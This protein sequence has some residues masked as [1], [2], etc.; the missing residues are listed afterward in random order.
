MRIAMAA[1]L[2]ALVL[3]AAAPAAASTEAA[4][5]ASARNGREACIATARLLW[6]TVSAA[7]GFSDRTGYDAM[8]VRG[9]YPQKFMKGA[10]GTMLCLYDRR[11]HRTEAVEAK[12]WA[13]H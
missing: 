12:G 5:K 8:L 11:T 3:V 10:T 1:G 7:V 6:P 4:W 13:A 2:V 9:I